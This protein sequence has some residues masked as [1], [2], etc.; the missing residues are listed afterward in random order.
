MTIQG[1]IHDRNQHPSALIQGFDDETAEQIKQLFPVSMRVDL[2]DAVREEEWD[3]LVT[4]ADVVRADSHLYVIA[5]GSE[6]VGGFQA[7]T[8]LMTWQALA[9][10]TLSGLSRAR[11]LLVPDGL[12]DVVHELVVRDLLPKVKQ[13]ALKQYVRLHYN[14]NQMDV[15]LKDVG[16]PIVPFLATT[17]PNIVAGSFRRRGNASFCWVLPEYVDAVAWVRAALITWADIDS[18]R[19]PSPPGWEHAPMWRTS[20]EV[21][22]IGALDAFEGRAAAAVAELESERVTLSTVAKAATEAADA[23]DRLLITA[24]GE[25]LAGAVVD[26]LQALGFTVR[27]MDAERAGRPRR[28]DLQLTLPDQPG[29]VCVVEVKGYKSGV[30][31]NDLYQVSQHVALFAQEE[32]ALPSSA[33]LVVNPWMN[34]DPS[35]RPPLLQGEDERVQLFADGPPP[36]LIVDSVALFKLQQMVAKGELDQVTAR[37]SLMQSSGRY[38]LPDR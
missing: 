13:Q 36:G 1:E 23:S 33:W 3:V 15:D 24:Q 38:E 19:F 10:V 37:D 5:I 17:E 21:D 14:Q 2:L 7:P 30:R 20:R 32:G 16:D 12:S 9:R 18:V 28:E 22:A 35:S 31:G 6:D 8:T 4:S 26:A 34:D 27:D 29:W 11:E 25:P